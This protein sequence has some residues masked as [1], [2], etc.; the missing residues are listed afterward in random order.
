MFGKV[1]VVADCH[2]EWSHLGVVDG[3]TRVAG[4]VVEF[5]V[6][7]RLFGYVEHAAGPEQRSVGIDDR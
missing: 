4:P 2:A 5:L 6:V 7:A 1:T 3:P